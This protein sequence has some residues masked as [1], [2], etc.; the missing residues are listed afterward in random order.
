MEP[1]TALT[2]RERF[3]ALLFNGP[4][5]T[6]DAIVVLCGEDCA[7]RLAVAAELM[8]SQA[9]PVVMLSG[10][11]DEPPRVMGAR[12]GKAELMGLGVAPSRIEGEARSRN[13]REQATTVCDTARSRGWRRILLVASAYHMPRAFLTFVSAAP[14]SLH[15][16]PVPASQAPWNRAPE[17]AGATRLELLATEAAKVAKYGAL[18]H[19]ASYAEGIDYLLRW[20]GK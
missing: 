15:V 4:L 8:G 16:L 14:E 5:L 6:G 11:I 17:G 7:P 19:V 2:D 13:T 10:G 1:V 18:G 9:A 20:E 12:R 3:H